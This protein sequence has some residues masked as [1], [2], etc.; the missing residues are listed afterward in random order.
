MVDCGS[1][2][3]PGPN[4]MRTIEASNAHLLNFL[5]EFALLLLVC[6]DDAGVY[7]IPRA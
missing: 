4:D 1:C 6:H 7:L 3:P 5:A 2:Q